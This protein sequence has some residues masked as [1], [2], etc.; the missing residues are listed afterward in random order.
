M[1]LNLKF[2]ELKH[3]Y[4][5]MVYIENPNEEEQE[6]YCKDYN[7]LVEELG[8]EIHRLDQLRKQQI[9]KEEK[10]NKQRKRLHSQIEKKLKEEAEL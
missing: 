3:I 9:E 5:K 4:E 2:T 10:R 6:D 1:T 8:E 7:N